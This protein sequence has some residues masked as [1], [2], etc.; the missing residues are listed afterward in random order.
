M[1]LAIL[2]L[3]PVVAIE[4]QNLL[5]KIL[6]TKVIVTYVTQLANVTRLSAAMMISKPPLKLAK[7]LTHSVSEFCDTFVTKVDWDLETQPMLLHW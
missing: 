1:I 2:L 7:V 4:N 6:T 5:Y 3:L